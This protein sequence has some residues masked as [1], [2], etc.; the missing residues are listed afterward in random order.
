MLKRQLYDSEW[1][2]KY[3]NDIE[4]INGNLNIF[5]DMRNTFSSNK[6]YFLTTLKASISSIGNSLP[7]VLSV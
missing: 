6:N 4:R 7:I 5:K 2:S 3:N 1:W